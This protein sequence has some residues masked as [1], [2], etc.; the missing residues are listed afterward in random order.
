MV[1]G[2]RSEVATDLHDSCR[3][4]L[5]MQAFWHG[6]THLQEP[7]N[8]AVQAALTQCCVHT[9]FACLGAKMATG[10]PRH[11]HGCWPLLYTKILS[12]QSAH[13]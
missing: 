6:A 9:V 10:L 5:E 13:Y 3:F 4:V 8:R 11:K 7:M 1:H 12:D 2:R